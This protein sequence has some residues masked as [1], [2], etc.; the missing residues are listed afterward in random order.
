[1]NAWK[2]IHEQ[3]PEWD[4]PKARIVGGAEPGIFD[5]RYGRRKP[6]E[7]LPGDWWRV[8]EQGQVLGYGW[9]DIVW[10]DAEILL[11]TAPEARGRGVGAFILEH[12]E[13]EARERRVN[14]VY[15]TVRPTHPHRAEVSRWLVQHGF[16]ASE[17][18]SLFQAVVPRG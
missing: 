17:D 12:L 1:M 8:E 15:N 5:V 16:R 7:L 18:G 11:A 9:M 10:G 4:A 6:G 2:W 13:A 3:P 14:Q